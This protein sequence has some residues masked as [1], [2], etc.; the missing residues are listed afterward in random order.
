MASPT[1]TTS[2]IRF[3]AVTIAAPDPR[4]LVA[5]YAAITGGEVIHI[6]GNDWAGMQCA[7]GRIDAMAVADYEPPRWPEDSSLIHIDVLVEDLELAADRVEQA[8][9]ARFAFQPNAEHCLVFADPVG[10]PF[11]LTLV[12]IPG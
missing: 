9:G 5:F 4:A 1:S 6:P 3:S 2:P 12:D 8:G 10:H 11:C 7:G